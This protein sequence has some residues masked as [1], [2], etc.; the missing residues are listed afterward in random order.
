M[1]TVSSRRK[2]PRLDDRPCHAAFQ[3]RAEIHEGDKRDP[4]DDRPVIDLTTMN[5][6]A[7][8]DAG[9][10]RGQ[11]RLDELASIDAGEGTR[12]PDLAECSASVLVAL[13]ALKSNAR[14]GRLVHW[15]TLTDWRSAGA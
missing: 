15:V 3:R 9:S 11:V 7:T 8:E 4:K 1:T 5:V 14:N 12:P 2:R 6:E 10:G 13:K